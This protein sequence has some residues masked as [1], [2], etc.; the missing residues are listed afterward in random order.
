MRNRAKVI[1][2]AVPSLRQ[3]KRQGKLRAE[4]VHEN[5]HDEHVA[6]VVC[7]PKGGRGTLTG[8]ISP[9]EETLLRSG[10]PGGCGGA[11]AALRLGVWVVVDMVGSLEGLPKRW[12]S[13]R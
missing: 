3:R 8:S 7:D 13:W 5:C 2:V 6:D 1:E 12:L 11:L 4:K 10:H 9:K